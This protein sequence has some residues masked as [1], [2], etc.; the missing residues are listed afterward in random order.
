MKFQVVAETQN[1]LVVDKPPFLLIHPSKPD[2][3]PRKLLD[4]SRLHALDNVVAQGALNEFA[5]RLAGST[6]G[7][8]ASQAVEVRTVERIRRLAVGV[9]LRSA[10]A[11]PRGL[12]RL[13]RHL[14]AFREGSA[15]NRRASLM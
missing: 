12:L 3:T 4:V 8:V 9:R 2:G 7:R 11:R 13:W 10:L 5:T 1:Y 15:R 6:P 14:P